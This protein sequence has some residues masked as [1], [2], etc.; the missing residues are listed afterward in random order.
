LKKA[1]RSQQRFGAHITLEM[2]G[3]ICHSTCVTQSAGH[4]TC[5]L[6][7]GDKSGAAVLAEVIQAKT[8]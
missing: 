1:L 7:C 8:G 5:D 4:A 3:W 2:V 6:S